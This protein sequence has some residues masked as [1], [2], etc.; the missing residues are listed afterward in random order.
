MNSPFETAVPANRKTALEI[1]LGGGGA[2]VLSR[3]NRFHLRRWHVFADSHYSVNRC[4]LVIV[5]RAKRHNVLTPQICM[6]ALFYE[7]RPASRLCSPCWARRVVAGAHARLG[8]VSSSAARGRHAAITCQFGA[9]S[10]TIHENYSQEVLTRN[11][12]QMHIEP[13]MESDKK[14]LKVAAVYEKSHRE[15]NSAKLHCDPEQCEK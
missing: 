12:P 15:Y 5:F 4:P 14:S 9:N 2:D 3:W 1:L 7:S 10:E 11:R 13:W 6:K 8:A